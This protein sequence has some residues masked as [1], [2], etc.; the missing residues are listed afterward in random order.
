VLV[1][2]EADQQRPDQEVGGEVEGP[3]RLGLEPAQQHRV[4]RFHGLAGE[5]RPGHRRKVARHDHLVGALGVGPETGA[6]H[7]VAPDDLGQRRLKR[8]G[9]ER[10]EQ[11]HRL[12]QVVEGRVDAELME[13]PEAFLGVRERDPRCIRAGPDRGP[14]AAGLGHGATRLLQPLLQERALAA[15]EIGR[16]GSGRRNDHVRSRRPWPRKVPNLPRRT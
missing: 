16:L 1:R 13:E 11:A 3:A 2:P 15:G 6:K 8:G 10:S 7:V 12:V 9:V 5:V 14:G 4:A